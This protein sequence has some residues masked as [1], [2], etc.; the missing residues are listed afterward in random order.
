MLR[1]LDFVRTVMK[2]TNSFQVLL[3]AC[4]PYSL[5]WMA[6]ALAT[7]VDFLYISRL[8]VRCFAVLARIG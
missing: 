6:A 4:F 1:K 3:F 7:S 5:G 8:L 2:L